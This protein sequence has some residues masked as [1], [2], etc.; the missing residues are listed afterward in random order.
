MKRAVITAGLTLQG[1]SVGIIKTT[2]LTW[3]SEN[4]PTA[5]RGPAMAL[6]P[7][8]TLIGQLIGAVVVFVVNKVESSTGYLGAFG[9]QWIL[10]LGPFILPCIMPDSPA[11]LIRA[12]KEHQALKSAIRLF[13]P[14]A[15]PHVVL[16]RIRH[17][18]EEEKAN[19]TSA[20]YW[21]CFSGVDRRRTLIVILA[22]IFPALFGLDLLSNYVPF[23][24]S[25]GM[26]SN[27]S[28]MLQIFGIVGGMIANGIGFWL[29]SRTG[30][31]NMTMI[32]MSVTGFLWGAM[33]VT[34]FWSSPILTYVAGGI[35]I[36]VIVVCGLGYWPAGYAIMGEASSLQLR[37]LTQGVGGVAAQGSSISIAVILPQLFGRDK[38]ALGAKTGFVFC[39]LSAIGV[40]M[41]WL[42]IPE[43]KGRS[44]QELDYMFKMK[45]P[46]REFKKK[47][48]EAY[49]IQEISPLEENER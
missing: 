14:K 45:L 37:A 35:M 19:A 28:L 17:T 13:A 32:S 49:E 31:R 39:G 3:V 48:I 6:F 15:N 43:M 12:G 18:I 34:G 22:N 2:C 7:T 42:W 20:N 25:F 30:R 1:L 4:S 11:Y 27:T 44:I 23:L 21:T 46:T 24:Q 33:G 5:L 16:E 29:L 40:L 9:S 8:F 26:E 10:C 36:G 38:A 47:K 41:T